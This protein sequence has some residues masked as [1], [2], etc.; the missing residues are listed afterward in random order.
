VVR[1]D[2]PITSSETEPVSI[3][4]SVVANSTVLLDFLFFPRS[5]DPGH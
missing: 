5:I 2:K 3:D 1:L 4:A